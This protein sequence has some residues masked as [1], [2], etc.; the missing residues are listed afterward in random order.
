MA[1][2]V[3]LW[4]DMPTDPK[5][6]VIARRSGQPLAGVIA[7]F[8]YM[9]TVA[10]AARDRGS[11]AGM[12]I[13]DAAAVLDMDEEAVAAILS[14][15]E[16][17]VIAN[18][19]LSGWESRQVIR[20]DDGAAERKRR[21]RQREREGRAA[22]EAGPLSHDADDAVAASRSGT[23]PSRNVTQRPAQ[24]T[25]S[26]SDSDSDTS[27]ADAPGNAALPPIDPTKL[28]FDHGL[29]L[30]VMGGKPPSQARSILGRWRRDHG[31]A[32]VIEAI[33][34]AQAEKASEPVAFIEGWFRSRAGPAGARSP[35]M[36]EL[37]AM[38]ERYAG[39]AM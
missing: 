12:S 35:V 29:A 14:E 17:R 30:L 19:R 7:L 39:E 6:R 10:S 28:V 24:D 5:W 38:R 18:G 37:A 2:W 34:R 22:G 11:I 4:H 3:R 9:L 26:D 13:E 23:H 25:E 1:D 16:G 27:G 36:R 33:G 8:T 20:E 31:D 21:Q 15:M 32:A